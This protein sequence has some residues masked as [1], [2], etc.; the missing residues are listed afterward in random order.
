M[1]W[2]RLDKQLFGKTDVGEL[3][4]LQSMHCSCRDKEKA[5]ASIKYVSCFP[6]FVNTKCGG[7][8]IIVIVFADNE[9]LVV[10]RVGLV[11]SGGPG[12]R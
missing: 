9:E 8:Q 5:S 1:R 12:G 3:H 10:D 7:E 6:N 2:Q 11:G 4:Q